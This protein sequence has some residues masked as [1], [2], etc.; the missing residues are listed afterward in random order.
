MDRF[1]GNSAKESELTQKRTA[2]SPSD[3]F[4]KAYYNYERS[5]KHRST[6]CLWRQNLIYLFVYFADVGRNISDTQ[7]NLLSFNP[8]LGLLSIV[9]KFIR[10]AC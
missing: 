1:D 9:C 5:H 3:L 8:L 4:T 7:A 10:S 6:P 2:T